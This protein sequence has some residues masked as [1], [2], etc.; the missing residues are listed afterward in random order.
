MAK[1]T[2]QDMATVLIEKN[3]LEKEEAQQFVAAIF[4]VIQ[5]GVEMDR[6]VKIKGLGTFKVTEVEPRESVNVNTGER[7]LIDGHSKISFV[8]DATMKELV[9]KPFSSFETVVLNDGVKF[10]DTEEQP[11][12]ASAEKPEEKKSVD[13]QPEVKLV[14]EE[15]KSEPVVEEPKSEPVIE[16]PKSEP[17]VEEPKSE[18]VIEEPKSEPVVE[19]SK[20][21]PVVEQPKTES[22]VKQAQAIP[23]KEKVVADKPADTAS[24][25]PVSKEKNCLFIILLLIACFV[26]GL[27]AGSLAKKMDLFSFLKDESTEPSAQRELVTDSVQENKED[28]MLQMPAVT[29]DSTRSETIEEKKDSVSTVK[30][31]TPS[32]A[33]KTAEAEPEYMKYDAMDNRVRLG[34]YYIDGFDR[35]V[36]ARKGDD[37]ELLSRRYFG[38]G[39]SCYV[40]VYNGMT[41]KT[42]L[43]AGQKIR[44]PKLKLRKDLKKKQ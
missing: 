40:E 31:A 24:K 35:E 30:A 25:K 36:E 19:E 22:V 4:D 9:N 29:D 39:M 15:Q 7:V 38:K 3:G 34:A 20:S 27:V 21:E 26:I 1:L 11:K 6:L 41:A 33:T 37:I 16:E 14:V 17:V 2:I 44:L 43:E 10:E 18:P 42:K 8:P 28:S 23:I 13:E 5:M 32:T 12:E